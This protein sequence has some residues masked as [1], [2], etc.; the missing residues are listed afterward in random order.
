MNRITLGY[1]P[2]PI[3]DL[4]DQLSFSNLS[5]R[6][7][8]YNSLENSF[9]DRHSNIKFNQGKH[10]PLNPKAPCF[11]PTSKVDEKSA[12]I[13]LSRNTL[14]RGN[15]NHNA[16]P[17][18]PRSSIISGNGDKDGI[19]EIVE[20]DTPNTSFELINELSL[21]ESILRSAP[22]SATFNFMFYNWCEF[23]AYYFVN[24]LAMYAVLALVIGPNVPDPDGNILSD[25]DNVSPHEFLQSLR[26]KN[27]DRIIIGQLNINSIRNKIEVLGDLIKDRIDILLIS[28][29]KIDNSFPPAQF[30]I[31]GFSDPYRLDRSEHGGGLL[32]YTRSD[33]TT[34]P[35]PLISNGIECIIIEATISKKKW[36]LFGIYNP[37]K[38]DTSLFLKALDQNLCHYLPS[39]DNV[40]L[41]GDFNS[42]MSEKPMDDFCSLYNLKSLIKSPTCFKSDT[43]PS[44]IDLIL[45]NRSNSF[46]NSSTAETGLSDFHHLVFTVLKTTF[47]KKP[48]KVV[49]YRDYKNYNSFNYFNDVNYC[50]AGI[51]LYQIPHD[52]YDDLLMKILDRH[53][54][55]KSKYVRGNDQPFM[56]TE[57]RKEHMKRTRLLN[58]YRKNR[59]AE[60]ENAYK[61]Q[62]NLCTNLLKKV[63]A[64]YYS[65]LKPANI[66]DNK[67]FWNTIKPLF[68]EK[69]VS[70]DDITLVENKKI[71]SDDK[72]IADIFNNFFS[73]AVKSLNI[74]YFEHF[75]WDCVFSQNEDPVIKAIEKYNKHPSIIKIKENYPQDTTFSFEPT[76]FESVLK[77]ILKLDESKS[78]PIESVPARVLK[79]IKDILCP[80]IVIDFNAS[81]SSG[82]FPQKLKLA[83]VIP[84]FKKNI[85]QRKEN[86]RPVSLLSAISKIFG[87]LMLSQMNDYMVNILSIFLCGFR[88]F[89]NAQ[90]CLVFL[91][92][93][94]R[95]ALDK[96]KKCGVLLTDLSK[97]FDCLLHDLLIAKLHAYG[98]DYLS[99][100][101]IYSYLTGRKQRVRVNAS[102]SEW[103]NIDDG[104]PQGSILGPELY[105]YYSNDLFLFVILEIA[106]YA[107]D[108]SPFTVAQSIPRVIE[109]LEADAKNLLSWIQ[110]NGL[111][112]NPDKFHM[113]LSD[114]D[115]NLLMKVNGFDI[116]NTISQ[117]LLGV[118]IDNKLSF[119]IHVESL[120]TNASQ[121]VHALSRVSN[122]MFFER[123]RTIMQTFILSQFGY[124]PLVWMFHSRELNNRINRIHERAL[125]LVYQDRTLSF[126]ELLKKDKSFT[127]HE[128]N[129]QTLG[130]E[131]YKVAHGTAPKIMNLVFP[132]KPDVKYPWNNIFQTFNVKTTA[133]GTETLYHLGPKIWSIIPMEI[134]K[135]PFRK[136]ITQIRLW[137][138]DKCPC[139]LCK[140][141]L[142]GVGFINVAQ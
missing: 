11:I 40:I 123:R 85:K 29:T 72:Q 56:T 127:I 62:R 81:I 98:F 116:L 47:R 22:K 86:H 36:L 9:N 108:N 119:K 17:F 4:S 109:N 33:I 13:N 69:C 92:E 14:R 90:N 32:L 18:I 16:T 61:K 52:D 136:F 104:V 48:P 83:D 25:D 43:N 80:K 15:L 3:N 101:L 1:K 95:K 88:K 96:S 19:P 134:K 7:N 129:I 113:L 73:N 50:L 94:W 54:P 34:K 46:Q 5:N 131:L 28:E 142:G 23:S 125:R 2:R 31:N 45:T 111:K 70:R 63:K 64:S 79:D 38:A 74:D 122:Y 24:V 97:A 44:C 37:H 35:L 140:F 107:D 102:Y 10:S 30:H 12:L 76:N 110:Y 66:C 55:L 21:N 89:M 57:L 117:K 20:V 26:L 139:R 87:R 42:E 67:K 60:N 126:E 100:K 75:S 114:T 82:I 65:N 27:V 103:S 77:E 121:K 135:L 84:L 91:T 118:K 124:C 53:A 59:N 130:I 106:N 141:Y 58:K 39:Y 105:N 78:S 137:K 51:D 71:I 115:V 6:M 112:A 128:R 41:L 138:P 132:T 8:E 93:T 120:C 99:L 68:S 49:R 133:W